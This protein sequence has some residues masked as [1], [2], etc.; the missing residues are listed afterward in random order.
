MRKWIIA[1]VS[2]AAVLTLAACHPGSGPSAAGAGVSGSAVPSVAASSGVSAS[3]GAA[4]SPD[5][6]PTVSLP[7]DPRAAVLA[8]ANRLAK[9]P[10]KLNFSSVGSSATGS[11][12]ITHKVSQVATKLND[13]TTITVR[14]LG[15]DQYVK[16]DGAEAAAL[17]ATAGK[18]MQVD[19]SSLPAD[20]PLS[21]D[22]NQAAAAAALLKGAKSVRR[23]EA[24]NFTGVADLSTGSSAA[25]MPAAL[26]TKMRK[27]PFAAAI[28]PWGRFVSLTFDL[29]AVAGG[30]GE[31]SSSYYD[32]GVPIRVD[33]PAPA[34]TVAMPAAF[35]QA[36][37]L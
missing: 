11:I 13:G 36:I 37:G 32:Y 16:V 15:A 23:E 9:Q 35:R 28:D 5:P 26:K 17:H 21:P 1:G 2:L 19:T 14:Q 34:D 30:A 24:R 22:R 3:P 12:D 20:N 10:F 6:G 8:A 4:G 18:W 31:L 33:R 7:A 29:N 25:A 27:V